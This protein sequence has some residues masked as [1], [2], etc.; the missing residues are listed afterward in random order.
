LPHALWQLG[1][2]VG[3]L[4]LIQQEGEFPSVSSYVQRIGR[5]GRRRPPQRCIAHVTDEFEFLKNLA[6]M[7]LAETG[8]VEDNELPRNS[9]HLLLQ[10]VLITALG[11]YGFPVQEV[12]GILRD[13]AALK[14]ISDAE[15]DDLL[16]F[17]LA[18]DV[19]RVSDGMLLIGR[20]V[21][22]LYAP[23]NYRDLYVLFDSPQIFE[24]W[25]GRNAIGTLDRIFVHSRTGKFVFILAGKWWQVEEVRYADGVVFVKPVQK[26][27]PPAMWIA[28]RGQEVSYR[29]A[30]QIKRLLLQDD[31]WSSILKQT[32]ARDFLSS[33][34]DQ[35]RRHGLSDEAIQFNALPK[36]R[37]EVVNY[38]GDRVNLL[39]SALASKR[40]GWECDDVT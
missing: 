36:N 5:T 30:Q 35:A 32:A 31:S 17:W 24:V 39:L 26:T 38:A 6:I 4:D 2:D 33:L 34:R 20:A 18:R 10:Q 37:Y 28:P 13:S 27:P 21:E 9:Y 3:D 11:S 22:Q 19:L 40:R 1:L 14:D 16:D 8:F 29:L 7:T 25:H 23:T 12:H 15:L